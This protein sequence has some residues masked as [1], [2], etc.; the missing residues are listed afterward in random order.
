[1]DKDDAHL[2]REGPAE[3]LEDGEAMMLDYYDVL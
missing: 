1:M 3:I 2:N